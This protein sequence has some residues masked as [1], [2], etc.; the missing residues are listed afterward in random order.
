V[1]VRVKKGP[2]LD[3]ED[4]EEFSKMF[5]AL[6]SE[7]KQSQSSI[8]IDG[9]RS[10]QKKPSSRQKISGK[11]WQG[12]DPDIID[13]IRRANT[14]EEAM[15]VIDFMLHR[16]EISKEYANRLLK[17]LNEHGLESFG[18]PKPPGYYFHNFEQ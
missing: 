6:A 15:D 14:K 17:Q 2:N 7:L 12:Y 13:F 18:S 11:N 8:K 16:E 9:V 4:E 5:P 1:A 3:N 10:E